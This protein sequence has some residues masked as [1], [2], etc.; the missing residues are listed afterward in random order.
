MLIRL[1]PWRCL[2]VIINPLGDRRNWFRRNCPLTFSY[3]IDPC[4]MMKTSFPYP[5]LRDPSSLLSRFIWNVGVL[6]IISRPNSV[7]PRTRRHN[8]MWFYPISFPTQLP[9]PGSVLCT[10]LLPKSLRVERRRNPT[11]TRALD[12]ESRTTTHLI[13][14]CTVIIYVTLD[15]SGWIKR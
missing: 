10:F 15:F 13:I 5:S 14:S 9:S 12:I 4:L 11:K 7:L 1:H 3:P 6:Q 8:R 2:G